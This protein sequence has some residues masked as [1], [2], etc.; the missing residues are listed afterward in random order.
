MGFFTRFN[1][2]GP[3]RD[4]RLYFHRRGPIELA[5]LGAALIGTTV[6][7]GMFVIDSPKIP[8]PEQEIVY[9]QQWRADRTD[10]EIVAQQ[11]KDKPAEDA[12][13]EAD[14]QAQLKH[15]AELKRLQERMKGWG[16]Y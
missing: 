13:R 4:L 14:R 7:F 5:F 11:K 16:F 10:E 1:P 3:L 2:I 6:V 15:Q 8:K 9:V 12:A